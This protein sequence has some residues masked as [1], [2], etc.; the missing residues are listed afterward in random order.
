M[1]LP[2][3]MPAADVTLGYAAVPPATVAARQ[4]HRLVVW[5]LTC[6]PLMLLQIP[7]CYAGTYFGA[8]AFGLIPRR[9]TTW[10]SFSVLLGPDPAALLPS[11]LWFAGSAAAAAMSAACIHRRRWR[12]F[13]GVAAFCMCLT[14]PFGTV[15]GLM[16]FIVLLRRT[17]ADAYAA[18]RG[19]ET[20]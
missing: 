19:Q 8:Q 7:G 5:N 18:R 4:L 17:S 1:T 12:W 15:A 2:D 10:A 6:A 3:P 16:T 11:L 9:P 13:S 14:V 20:P